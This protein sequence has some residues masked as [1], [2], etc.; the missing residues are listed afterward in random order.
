MDARPDSLLLT[1]HQSTAHATDAG[2]NGP[3][4]G[5]VVG[6]VVFVAVVAWMT[7]P[8]GSDDSGSD[9]G[10]GGGGRPPKPRPPGPPWWPEFERDFAEYVAGL[11]ARSPQPRAPTTVTHQRA[12]DKRRPRRT[13]A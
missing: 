7:R 4:L 5:I 8:R 2:V 1:A 6:L 13:E 3:V 11:R 9:G 12:G 10:G